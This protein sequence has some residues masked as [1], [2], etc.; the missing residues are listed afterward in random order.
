[1]QESLAD[2]G[3]ILVRTYRADALEDRLGMLLEASGD[4]QE[5][6]VDEHADFVG[7]DHLELRETGRSS[8]LF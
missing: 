1:M 6:Q 5:A 7:F 2:I 4:C 3:R 8:Q